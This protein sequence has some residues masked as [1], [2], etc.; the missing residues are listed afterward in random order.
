MK[1]YTFRWVDVATGGW[2]IRDIEARDLPAAKHKAFQ[3]VC[4]LSGDNLVGDVE[5]FEHRYTFECKGEPNPKPTGSNKAFA[6]RDYYT[7]MKIRR[8]GKDNG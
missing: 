4:D 7:G 1:R 2:F 8:G 5:I 3:T 6:K